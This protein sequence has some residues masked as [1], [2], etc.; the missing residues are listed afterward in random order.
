MILVLAVCLIAGLSSD[1]RAQKGNGLSQDTTGGLTQ[2][3]VKIANDYGKRKSGTG[4]IFSPPVGI[5]DRAG[6]VFRLL[7]SSTF[8]LS[9]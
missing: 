6:E 9:H 3:Q 7:L 2:A 4:E 1:N 8:L 5:R